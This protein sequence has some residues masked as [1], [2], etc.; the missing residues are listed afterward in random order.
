MNLRYAIILSTMTAFS[1]VVLTVAACGGNGEAT[2]DTPTVI[3]AGVSPTEDSAA[4]TTPDD[5]VLTDSPTAALVADAPDTSAVSFDEYIMMVCGETLTEVGSWEGGNSL[6]DLSAGLGFISEQ[7]SALEPPTEVA[8]WHDA[9]IV[10]AGVFKDTIDDFLEEPGDRTEDEFIL[11]MFLTVA[12]VFAPVEQAI[13]GMD[14]EV[15]ARMAEAGCIDEELSGVVP[16]EQERMEVTVGEWVEG[17]LAAPDQSAFLEFQAEMGQKYFIEVA[18]V[19]FP[20]LYLLIK[21]PPDP[22]VNSVLMWNPE[23]SPSIRRWTAPA[24]GTFHVD[25]GAY[26]GAGTYAIS[27]SRDASPDAPTGVIAAWEGTAV[28]V[29]W[30]PAEGAE[31]Y[32]VYHDELGP[33]CQVDANGKASFCDE[34]ATDATGT[35]YVHSSP[36]PYGNFYFVVACNREGCSQ[37]DSYNPASP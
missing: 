10:F 6:K 32:K 25:V 13:A 26:E 37:I 24:S 27:I 2:S 34:L 8:E 22:V 1:I 12:P 14:P 16:A 23:I 20:D 31:Y 3:D 15:R 33:G 28:R 18:W 30:E 17:D 19:G 35:S 4:A 29:R 5:S 7:M 36:D 9:Q 21:D 11:S